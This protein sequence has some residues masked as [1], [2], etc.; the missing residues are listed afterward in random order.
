VRPVATDGP[1]GASGTTQRPDLPPGRESWPPL[2]RRPRPRR[3]PALFSIRAPIPRR[4]HWTLTVASLVV[5]ILVWS[6]VYALAVVPPRFLPAPWAVVDAGWDMAATGQLF[7]DLWATLQRILLGFGLAVLV[8]V[9][10]GILMGTFRAG[11]A[12]LEPLVG[13]LR[14]MPATAFIPL[15]TIWLGVEEAPKVALLFIGTVFCNTLMIADV[16]RN[17]PRAVIDV[18]Y[19]L[20]ARRT[21][22]VRKVIVPHA[23]PG[24][25]DAVRVNVAA[26]FNLVVVAELIAAEAGLGRRIIQAQRFLQTEKI[27]AILIMIGILG[28]L[29]DVG[30][31]LLRSWVGRWAA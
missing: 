20:G 6:V 5:P 23:L 25:I 11:Q 15:L 7:T 14:Y 16:V 9:P 19:T 28:V 12:A 17:V 13:F 29:I 8:S 4:W 30:L 21:E 27:F 1:A 22:V 24:M 2:P 10:L 18:S 3:P 31:R 26:A